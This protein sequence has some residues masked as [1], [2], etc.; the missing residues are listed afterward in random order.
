MNINSL[1]ERL[2]V[3]HTC[4]YILKHQSHLSYQLCRLSKSTINKT[5]TVSGM[6]GYKVAGKKT[7]QEQQWLDNRSTPVGIL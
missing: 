5:K 3:W 4:V 7:G 2:T 6:K 1:A